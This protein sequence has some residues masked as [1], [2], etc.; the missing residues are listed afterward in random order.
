MNLYH[1]VSYNK[2][3]GEITGHFVSSRT[4]VLPKPLAPADG[5][6]QVTDPQQLEQLQAHRSNPQRR[7]GGFKYTG[8]VDADKIIELNIVPLFAGG[9]HL[10]THPAPRDGILHTEIPADGKSYV[11]ITATLHDQ[12]GKAIGNSAHHKVPAMIY[13]QTDRGALSR[14]SVEVVNGKAHVELRSVTETVS[15][16]VTASADGFEPGRITIE[17]V[18]PDEFKEIDQ[19]HKTRTA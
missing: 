19:G 13:F 17:F 2:R 1:Y 5:H 6:L 9:V 11:K 16:H 12:N 18:P 3:T 7:P 8:R 15:A 14:R 4:D 10:S